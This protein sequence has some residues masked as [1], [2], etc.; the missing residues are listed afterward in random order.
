M[1]TLKSARANV[2]IIQPLNNG[3]YMSSMPDKGH[4]GR[5]VLTKVQ[6]SK[7]P[8]HYLWKQ[9]LEQDWAGEWTLAKLTG[10]KYRIGLDPS[11]VEELDEVKKGQ[12]HKAEWVLCENG[13]IVFLYSEEPL[14]FRLLTT[15]R[16]AE[17][18]LVAGVGASIY[19]TQED[20]LSHEVHFPGAQLMVV[21]KLAKA[22]RVK[23]ARPMHQQQKVAAKAHL[24][25]VRPTPSGKAVNSP[26]QEHQ[27]GFEPD[28]NPLSEVTQG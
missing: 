28:Q 16:T 7:T 10:Y 15:K 11:F 24:N 22:R 26:I 9:C 23:P 20:H 8:E 4:I 14:V 27:N 18:V 17:K 12:L 21:C 2:I 13:G 6:E 19:Q 25:K 3:E 5:F 1:G